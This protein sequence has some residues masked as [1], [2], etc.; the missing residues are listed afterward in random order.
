MSIPN[1]IVRSMAGLLFLFLFIPVH[2]FGQSDTSAAALP[3]PRGGSDSVSFMKKAV[4]LTGEI[5]AYGELYGVSGIEKRR[6][7]STARLYLR[8]TLC[9][10]NTLTLNF[11][12]LLSTEGNSARQ[13]LDQIA[14]ELVSQQLIEKH[15]AQQQ[16]QQGYACVECGQLGAH[17]E[18]L[19]E[20][21]SVS[22]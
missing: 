3:A 19:H 14:V 2:V 4:S 18:R 21:R 11:D 16:R 12:F 10:F 5:G 15:G 8:P 9:F 13:S 17:P 1:K 6:P 7:S 20:S 22:R